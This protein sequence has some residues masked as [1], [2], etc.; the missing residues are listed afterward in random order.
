MIVNHQSA[1]IELKRLAGFLRGPLLLV[2][3]AAFLFYNPSAADTANPDSE[4]AGAQ[5]LFQR[6][7]AIMAT[8]DSLRDASLPE[9]ALALAATQVTTARAERDSSFLLQLMMRQGSIWSGFGQ[10]RQ[11][12]G[13]L[14][15]ALQLAEAQ[16]DSAALCFVLRWLSVAVSGQGRG[17]EAYEMCQRLLSLAR[18]QDSPMYEGWALVGLGW[19]TLS[20]G[21]AAEATELYR[22]AIHALRR[23]NIADGLAWALNGMGIALG[24]LGA[25]DQALVHFRQAAA[26]A[27]NIEI[28]NSRRFVLGIVL[29]NLAT[30]EFNFGDPSV[31]AGH[32]REAHELHI[33]EGNQR[34]AMM[35]GLNAAMCLTQIGRRTEAIEAMESLAEICRREGYLDLLGSIL[36]KLAPIYRLQGRN[37]DAAKVCRQSM[38][39]G[40][41]LPTHTQAE[42]HI[43][44]AQTLSMSD[45]C[46]AALAVLDKGA[47]LL[48]SAPDAQFNLRLRSERGCVLR[49]SGRNRAA[50]PYLLSVAGEEGK[51]GL[52]RLR[53]EALVT[54]ALAYQALGK[55]DS[56]LVLLEQAAADWE[57]DR[58]VPLDPKWREQRGAW[59][60]M[61]YTDLADLLLDD[62]SGLPKIEQAR[63]AFDRLQCFKARTLM[64]RVHGPGSPQMIPP[65]NAPMEITTLD[66]LQTEGL[67]PGELLLDPFLGPD[68][69]ILFAVTCGEC[70]AVRLP[71]EEILAPKLHLYRCMIEDPPSSANLIDL[72]LL[73]DVGK[74]LGQQLFGEV[75]D[76]LDA[77]DRIMIAPDG[78]LNLLPLAELLPASQKGVPAPARLKEVVRVPSASYLVWLRRKSAA[79]EIDR[80]TRILAI[81]AARGKDGQALPGAIDEVHQL[82]KSFHNVEAMIV[83]ADSCPDLLTER[84]ADYDLLHLAAHTDVDDN[85]PWRSAIQLSPGAEEGF[86]YAD[87]I[88]TLPLQARLVVLSSCSS[89]GGPIL[90][91]EGVLGLCTAFL[92]A[93]VP[94][95]VATLWDVDDKS[96][97][98]FVGRFYRHL[99]SDDNAAAALAAA[100]E[101]MQAN[102]RTRHPY[103]WA[104]FILTG[105]GDIRVNLTRRV[106]PLG[107]LLGALALIMIFMILAFRMCL[108][109]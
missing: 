107:Y 94:A 102:P 41:A 75:A 2:I 93:G 12:E 37:S 8:I 87:R 104:G 71:S 109:K 11:A 47:H 46:E 86:L 80:E 4:S 61:L 73:N 58:G 19:Q 60:R 20:A 59:S 85:S 29:N 25:Y 28:E 69:S 50:L 77:C 66:L 40:D 98:Q 6:H 81:A 99:A 97:A 103:F 36:N 51:Q 17:S 62:G 10:V 74:T 9:Q 44:L 5:I 18:E 23:E 35:P 1:P 67:R 14:R 82:A 76:L 26:A 38:S 100:Q 70:R 45:S 30:L 48:E 33:S 24:R 106:H 101:E 95:V 21:K 108:T 84:L 89:A 63:R 56:A 72:Q 31:A 34:A 88:T 54:A 32:F 7:T 43:F 49:R 3:L 22:Q 16:Q 53:L 68:S 64:E 39:L 105:D 96:T 65:A 52:S 92:S 79:P 57:S 15:E 13:T 78:I 83:K 27:E 42:A 55:P 90:S 91:G